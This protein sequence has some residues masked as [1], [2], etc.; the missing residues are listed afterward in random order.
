MTTTIE[1]E[2]KIFKNISEIAEKENTTETKLIN[3]M[4]KKALEIKNKKEIPEDLTMNKETYDPN[5]ELS[6]ELIG[7][8]ETDESFDT[9]KAIQE[10]RE[11]E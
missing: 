7:A 6:E 5:S 11:I 9:L 4:L 2:P 10:I 8:I 3:Q 1:I